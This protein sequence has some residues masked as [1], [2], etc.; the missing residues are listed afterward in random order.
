M[1]LKGLIC[2]RRGLFSREPLF[3]RNKAC[4]CPV[5]RKRPPMLKKYAIHIWYGGNKAGMIIYLS[6][7][8]TGKNSEKISRKICYFLQN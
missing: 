7:S 2:D 1:G 6:R 5:N 8:Y 3:P 4:M